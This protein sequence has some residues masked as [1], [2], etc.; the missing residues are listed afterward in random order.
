VESELCHCEPHILYSGICTVLKS[1]Q[2][3]YIKES[4]WILPLQNLKSKFQN[5]DLAYSKHPRVHNLN[6]VFSQSADS[7]IMSLALELYFQG[8]KVTSTSTIWKYIYMECKF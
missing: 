7:R 1:A 3:S 4:R 2:G 6:Y 8:A 5:V